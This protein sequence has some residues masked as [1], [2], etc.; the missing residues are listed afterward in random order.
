LASKSENRKRKEAKQK[1]KERESL[2]IDKE[3][4]WI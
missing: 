2:L 1:R 4:E 3:L